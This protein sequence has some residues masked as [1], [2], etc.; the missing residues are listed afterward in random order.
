MLSS[1]LHFANEASAVQ[2]ASDVHDYGGATQVPEALH[3]VNEA[4]VQ[5][6]STRQATHVLEVVLHLE[7]SILVQSVLLLHD[8]TAA[9][10]ALELLH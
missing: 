8:A 3:D 10:Q 1:V 6:A 9:A 2:S 7:C 5:S 4:S